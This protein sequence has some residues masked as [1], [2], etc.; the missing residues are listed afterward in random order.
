MNFFTGKPEIDGLGYSFLLRNYRADLGKWQIAD[1]TGYPDG[2][3]NF[4][5]VNNRTVD[6][7]DR[8]GDCTTNI[9]GIITRCNVKETQTQITYGEEKTLVQLTVECSS[10]AGASSE[11]EIT[12]NIGV[13]GVAQL[14]GL[15]VPIDIS[16]NY[17][18]P[19]KS[20]KEYI[21]AN[22]THNGTGVRSTRFLVGAAVKTLFTKYECG[23]V[24]S[25]IVDSWETFST[26]TVILTKCHE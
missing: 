23:Q 22:D 26:R 8:L 21:C 15:A 1:P 2:P 5:Y 25:E 19:V 24:S 14:W 7:Y 16:W 10:G 13:K 6:N 17:T 9:F 4:T 18:S 11:K 20:V 12:I 3:N